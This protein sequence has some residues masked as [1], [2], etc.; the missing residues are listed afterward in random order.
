MNI[1]LIDDEWQTKCTEILLECDK[2]QIDI[3]IAESICSGIYI[4]VS[5]RKNYDGIILDMDLP[6]LIDGKKIEELGGDIILKKMKEINKINPVLI[7]S[8]NK[9]IEKSKTD[10]VVGEMSEFKKEIFYDFL[11]YVDSK[12]SLN[13]SKEFVDSLL[14]SCAGK[15]DIQYFPKDTYLTDDELNSKKLNRLFKNLDVREELKK[16]EKKFEF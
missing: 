9:S 5:H 6:K 14:K 12:I 15:L 10:F 8:K 2:K 3:D 7:F 11:R 13:P 16:K 4:I 1:L